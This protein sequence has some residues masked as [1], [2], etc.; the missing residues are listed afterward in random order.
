MAACGGVVLILEACQAVA[1]IDYANLS[2]NGG[3]TSALAAPLPILNHL[4]RSRIS[5]EFRAD[6]VKWRNL[7]S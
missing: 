3:F 1:A 5:I 4:S 6:F 7:L 2:R